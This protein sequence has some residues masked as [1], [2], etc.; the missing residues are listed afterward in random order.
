MTRLLIDSRG[1]GCARWNNRRTLRLH[2]LWDVHIYFSSSSS[3]QRSFTSCAQK[4]KTHAHINISIYN[5]FEVSILIHTG[6]WRF[7]NCSK[8]QNDNN[9]CWVYL[10]CLMKEQVVTNQDSSIPRYVNSS[11]Q[12][13]TTINTIITTASKHPHQLP[14][15]NIITFVSSSR[16][17]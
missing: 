16:T 17:N 12:G 2:Y 14:F 9:N 3:M 1:E 15:E 7:P 10:Q 13:N 5:M 11:W 6:M 4:K 8:Q